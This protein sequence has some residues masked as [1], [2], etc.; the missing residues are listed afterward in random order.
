MNKTNIKRLLK[1]ADHLESG[2]L[3][4]KVFDYSEYN[5]MDDNGLPSDG[6]CGTRGCAIGECPIVFPRSWKFG[7]NGSPVLKKSKNIAYSGKNIGYSG[8]MFFNL[9]FDEFDALFKGNALNNSSGRQVF[10]FLSITAKRKTVANR[11]RKFVELKVE[12]II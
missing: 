4:H 5:V 2:K 11:L 9:S 10:K 3:G 7:K 12:G 8:V 1:L 6:T